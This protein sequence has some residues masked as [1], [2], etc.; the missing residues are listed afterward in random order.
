MPADV[1][2]RTFDMWAKPG[3]ILVVFFKSCVCGVCSFERVISYG[4][5]SKEYLASPD[6]LGRKLS[7]GGS[8][9]LTEVINGRKL[10][11]EGSYQLKEVIN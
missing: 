2:T 4:V 5:L 10:S 1:Q 11:T 3:A 6:A 7:T 8:Y 9:Q